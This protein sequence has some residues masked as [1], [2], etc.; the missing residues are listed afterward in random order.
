MLWYSTARESVFD[1]RLISPIHGLDFLGRVE[2]MYNDTW[3]TVCDYGF[4]SNAADVV[5]GML[6]YTRSV[7]PVANALM[8]PG[9]GKFDFNIILATCLV[10]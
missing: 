8:E 4:Y 9:S 3:G 2:V 10:P 5:C 7:C 1:V 6:N